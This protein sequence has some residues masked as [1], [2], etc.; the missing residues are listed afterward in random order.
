MARLN[1]RVPHLKTNIRYMER[2]VLTRRYKRLRIVSKIL[3]KRIY[4]GQRRLRRRADERACARA[5]EGDLEG[6]A[7]QYLSFLDSEAGHERCG[8]AGTVVSGMVRNL[9]VKKGGARY[10]KDQQDFWAVLL[11]LGGPRVVTWLRDNVN[12]PCLSSVQKWA[13]RDTLQLGMGALEDN[14]RLLAEVYSGIIAGLPDHVT[15]PVWVAEDES[16]C[17]KRI[18]WD[19]S[20]DEYI[21]W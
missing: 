18:I 5:R 11:R 9:V 7:R 12:G 8:S 1:G 14:F 10:T 20:L 4:R 6:C 17:Q 16:E 2:D 19:S 13:R 15:G 3:C 21:G